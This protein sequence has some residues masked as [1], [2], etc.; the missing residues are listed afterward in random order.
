MTVGD[1]V[2]DMRDGKGK[3]TRGRG[4]DNGAGKMVNVVKE[5]GV[6]WE[7]NI[8]KQQSAVKKLIRMYRSKREDLQW[9]QSGMISI[10]MNGEAITVVQNRV[11][12]VSFTDLDIIP[13]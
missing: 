7:Y 5:T 2:V 10:V 9:A 4:V 13:L 12:D 6:D 11:E 1:V 3:G 8:H